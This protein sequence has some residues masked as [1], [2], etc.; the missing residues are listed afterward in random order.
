MRL[1][2]LPDL[3]SQLGFSK[4]KIYQ[5]ISDGEFMKGYGE[6]RYRRWH[7]DEVTAYQILLW[8]LPDKLPT[9]EDSLLD[10]IRIKANNAKKKMLLEK[11]A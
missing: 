11:N 6:G 10:D 5:M 9:L 1:L 4:S 3:E 2:R 7:E 8:R